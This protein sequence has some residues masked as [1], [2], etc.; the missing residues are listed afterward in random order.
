[1][2]SFRCSTQS[3]R[4]QNDIVL[5]ALQGKN[6]IV[7]IFYHQ[8]VSPLIKTVGFPLHIMKLAALIH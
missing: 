5:E 4:L 1:M 2:G 8:V 3:K 6:L 7:D